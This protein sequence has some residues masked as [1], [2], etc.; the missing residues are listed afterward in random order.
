M[1]FWSPPIPNHDSKASKANQM[2]GGGSMQTILMP[3]LIR[4]SFR[5][6]G[7]RS[8]GSISRFGLRAFPLHW[9]KRQASGLHDE[10]PRIDF[11]RPSKTGKL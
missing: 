1:N 11:I 10:R 9:S 3:I 5:L 4:T 6:L 2:V 8:L 7:K